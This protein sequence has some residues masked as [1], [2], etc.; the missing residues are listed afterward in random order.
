VVLDDV[1]LA[2]HH[3]A[4]RDHAG[5]LGC[6][7]APTGPS[8]S[9]ERQRGEL[10]V[11]QRQQA[12]L[13][14]RDGGHRDLRLAAPGRPGSGA[15]ASRAAA[16]PREPSSTLSR[17]MPWPELEEGGAERG[18]GRLHQ[19]FSYLKIFA[20]D[21]SVNPT[22]NVPS[23]AP[24]SLPWIEKLIRFDTTSFASNLGLIETV[25]DHLEEQGSP[26]PSPTNP[27]ASK[28]NLFA[29]IPAADGA[30][31]GGIVLSG[32]TDV[33]PVKGQ[34]WD[35]DPVRARRCARASSTAAVPAT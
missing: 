14:L 13:R 21:K 32:H 7:T 11:A 17:T 27:P 5:R 26:R 12:A 2:R 15:C 1:L 24:I 20:Y 18:D 3:C 23:A 19:I 31:Q 29:T 22:P 33:V 28:A 34:D 4:A 8:C 9:A 10:L 6:R 16:Q 35:S 30:T 25:R